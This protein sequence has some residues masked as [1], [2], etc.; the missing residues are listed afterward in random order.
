MQ[1]SPTRSGFPT[2]GILAGTL[3]SLLIAFTSCTPTTGTRIVP[4]QADIKKI[5]SLSVSVQKAEDFS[6]RLSRQEMTATGAVLGSPFGLVGS[7]IGSGVEASSRQSADRSLEKQFVPVISTFSPTEELKSS[8]I[9]YLGAAKQFDTIMA[10][11]ASEHQ[12]GVQSRDGDAQL[13]VTIRQW[14]LRRCLGPITDNVQ[15][16][17]SLQANLIAAGG[18]VIWD[19]EELYLDGACEIWSNFRA[20]AIITRLMRA[21]DNMAGKLANELLYP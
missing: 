17:F 13:V 7:L 11:P 14:G 1:A 21:I 9:R 2:A 18:S 19:R 20:P 6:V 16:G 12:S 4:T 5:T 15:I 10:A 8:L 3:L